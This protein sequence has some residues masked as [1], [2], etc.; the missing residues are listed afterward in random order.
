MTPDTE[1]ARLGGDE[2]GELAARGQVEAV[3]NR[4]DVGF[5]GTFADEEARRDLTI[6]QA[7]G[8]QLRDLHLPRRE[9]V[10]GGAVTGAP[11][12]G[13]QLAE[14][15]TIP[16]SEVD[17]PRLRVKAR[18]LERRG[19]LPG[20]ADSF[21]LFG[22]SRGEG[23]CEGGLPL[24]PGNARVEEREV[25]ARSRVRLVA[26]RGSEQGASLIALGAVLAGRQLIDQP[27]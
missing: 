18:D 5:H 16:V 9:P 19:S 10:A 3:E 26:G 4:G 17:L 6:A 13:I 21:E 7:A 24:P 2:L 20:P 14:L 25:C 1:L 12:S 23:L 8:R 22:S 15:A 27:E 11:P